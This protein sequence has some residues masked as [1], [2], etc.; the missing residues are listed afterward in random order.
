MSQVFRVERTKNFT[1]MSNHHMK[2][3]EL[4][5]KA[6]GLLSIMLSL[7]DEW[8]YNLKG[9]ATLSK[10]GIDSVRSALKEL[11]YHGYVERH[12]IRSENGCYT[13]IEYIVREVPIGA[14]QE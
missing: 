1:I 7:P 3:K 8:N 12:R 4:T 5:L 11:E 10:D 2:D 6:K 14:V 9:L 13:D